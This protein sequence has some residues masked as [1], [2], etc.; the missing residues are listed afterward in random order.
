MYRFVRNMPFLRTLLPPSEVPRDIPGQCEDN[1]RFTQDFFG[2]GYAGRESQEWFSE[3]TVSKL[4]D[5]SLVDISAT[6]PGQ[7]VRVLSCSVRNAF[8]QVVPLIANIYLFSPDASLVVCIARLA[9]AG[10][11]LANERIPVLNHPPVLPGG[12]PLSFHFISG[13]NSFYSIEYLTVSV[14]R[15]TVFFV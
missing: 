11:T 15:G 13:D 9:I 10:G 14:P 8:A 4:A 3:R 7:I 12:C 2:G 6:P 1:V 5:N